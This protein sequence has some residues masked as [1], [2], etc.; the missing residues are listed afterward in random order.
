VASGLQPGQVSDII[1]G[2]DGFYLVKLIEKRD[3]GDVRFAKI[4]V[5]YKVVAQKIAD[6][7]KQNKISEFIK[8]NEIANPIS[9]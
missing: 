5:A 3:T 2:A 9:Q 7:K 1:E 6:L 4:F 8:V